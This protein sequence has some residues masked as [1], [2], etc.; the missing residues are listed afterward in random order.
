MS[1]VLF[2]PNFFI[3]SLF[4]C[5]SSSVLLISC[6]D[7]LAVPEIGFGPTRPTT[8]SR[9]STSLE[10]VAHRFFLSSR[11]S[12]P[13]Q[14]DLS[15]AFPV[16]EDRLHKVLAVMVNPTRHSV[17]AARLRTPN[18]GNETTNLFTFVFAFR[19]RI[20]ESS[21]AQLAGDDSGVIQAAQSSWIS[22]T[23]ELSPIGRMSTRAKLGTRSPCILF[24]L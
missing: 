13:A 23:S 10:M 9:E 11:V 19:Y 22:L 21:I 16:Q 2:I 12:T 14:A 7:R 18:F 1:C 15:P 8:V 4:T 17:S 3:I 5:S 6:L 24:T 20:N